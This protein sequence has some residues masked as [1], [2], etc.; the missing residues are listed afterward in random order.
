MLKKIKNKLKQIQEGDEKIKKRWIV[1]MS[2]LT[3]VFII[4]IWAV[5]LKFYS[6]TLE[7]KEN[8]EISDY[9]CEGNWQNIK[10]TFGDLKE[11]IKNL[12]T[13]MTTTTT[14]NEQ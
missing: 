7:I 8:K 1:V 9:N 2:F 13:T 5:Y 10:N 11:K 4:G 6:P 14:I 12:N 3:M